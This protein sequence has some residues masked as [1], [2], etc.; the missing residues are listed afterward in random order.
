M[1]SSQRPQ[2]RGLDVSS[3]DISVQTRLRKG[4]ALCN[5]MADGTNFPSAQHVVR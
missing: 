5:N 1:S 2:E 4:L 3:A